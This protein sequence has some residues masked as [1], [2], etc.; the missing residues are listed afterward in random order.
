MMRIRAD[1]LIVASPTGS[2]AY[3]LAAG[4]PILHPAVDALLLTPI[5]PHMLTNRPIVIPG[6]SAVHVRPAMD[7]HAEVFVTIDG[8]SGHALEADDVISIE[9][10]E[11]PLRLVRAAA[12]TYFE[13]LREKLKWNM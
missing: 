5:A 8:Q 2:T 3:N 10:A 13:V 6:T 1:G 11:R 4:G 12:R 7:G 9:R